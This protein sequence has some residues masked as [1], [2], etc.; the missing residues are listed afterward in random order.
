[1]MPT[2]VLPL[3]RRRTAGFSIIELL[4]AMTMA[5]GLAGAAYSLF[6]SQSRSFSDNVDRFDTIQNAR[7]A[8]EESERVIRTMGA[9]TPNN[10]PVLVYGAN[11]V[12]AFNTDYIEQDTVSTRWATYF[13]PD[14]PV[15][16][17][18]VWDQTNQTV[19]PNTSYT[20][21]TATYNLGNGSPSPAETYIFYF[22][23]DSSTSRTDDFI[24]YQRVNNGASDIVARNIL[25][26]PSGKPFFEYLM[27]RTL[28]SGD[29]LLSAS[30]AIIPLIRRPLVAGISSSDSAAYVRP[31]SVRAVRM[32][33]RLTNG[34]TG[35]AERFRDV[36]TTIEVPNNGI[37][38][39]TVCGRAPLQPGSLTV[40]DTVAGSGRLW[41]TWAKSA[42]QD[43]GE[44]D[45]L[46]Y[47]LYRRP[48]AAT[49]WADALVVLRATAGQASYS[50][51]ISNNEPGT[52]YTFGIAAQDCTPSQST[53]RTLN[54]TPSVGP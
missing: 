22:A 39:P 29:T 9:G 3:A 5:V 46:Q 34:R 41:F 51:E 25:A 4:I 35:T 21:P 8:M 36:T 42:D 13:N 7:S 16:E 40:V 17:T 11:D 44:D 43:A 53:F 37:P 14:T 48:Q 50:V 30:N 12:L 24:L 28:V 49:A 27:Q 6:R 26:H 47:I 1:M 33:F 19:I 23:P 31:D 38:L 54:V 2:P 18:V 45:V 10:Q 52:A 15:A 20:Y 32:N